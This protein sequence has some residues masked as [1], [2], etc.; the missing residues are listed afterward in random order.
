MTRAQGLGGMT[1]MLYCTTKTSAEL[2]TKTSA[3]LTTESVSWLPTL[4][5][6]DSEPTNAILKTRA[7]LT[8]ESMFLTKLAS[9]HGGQTSW[10]SSKTTKNSGKDMAAVS[11]SGVSFTLMLKYL[12][13]PSPARCFRRFVRLNI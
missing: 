2:T 4:L 3:E 13:V 12:I 8:A 10:K 7:E 5:T 9:N 6:T 11:H 1:T